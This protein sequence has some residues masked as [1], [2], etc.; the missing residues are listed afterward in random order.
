MSTKKTYAPPQ[1]LNAKQ[2][3]QRQ[4]LQRAFQFDE[5][6]LEANHNNYL[7]KKQRAL[8]KGNSRSNI[9]LRWIIPF[10]I[11]SI[12]ILTVFS[13]SPL[14]G[15]PDIFGLSSVLLVVALIPF[16]LFYG[17]PRSYGD[18]KYDLHKGEITFVEGVFQWSFQRNIST[19]RGSSF[20]IHSIVVGKTHFP[21]YTTYMSIDL[22]K[23]FVPEQIYR[24]YYLPYS[25]TIISA[26][27]V[28]SNEI[29]Q[30]K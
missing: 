27:W 7:S 18:L 10:G 22:V 19:F 9:V 20:P 30:N 8:L 11:L 16:Y 23:G 5:E 24:V 12:F 29:T 1:N 25:R 14:K 13:Q 26:E 15:K 6:D 4:S 2:R 21:D 3:R 28:D 17:V